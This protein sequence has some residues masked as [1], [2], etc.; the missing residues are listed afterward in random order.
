MWSIDTASSSTALSYDGITN[1][2]DATITTAS[3]FVA[4]VTPPGSTLPPNLS[5][6]TVNKVSAS[7]TLSLD[8]IQAAYP[9]QAPSEIIALNLSHTCDPKTVVTV[10]TITLQMTAKVEIGTTVR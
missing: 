9:V 5:L 7:A 6:T 8:T 3:E 4:A 1:L 10:S 2:V